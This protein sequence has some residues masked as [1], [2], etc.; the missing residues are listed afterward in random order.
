MLECFFELPIHLILP[1]NIV[2]LH[3]NYYKIYDSAQHRQTQIFFELYENAILL[4]FLF[5]STFFGNENLS[6]AVIALNIATFTIV[7]AIQTYFAAAQFYFLFVHDDYLRQ[8]VTTV[9]DKEYSEA[10][11]NENQIFERETNLIMSSNES[12]NNNLKPRLYEFD[13]KLD[14]FKPK[15]AF[16]AIK[17]NDLNLS[18]IDLESNFHVLNTD[19]KLLNSCRVDSN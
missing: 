6:A 19:H 16:N 15:T 9:D 1:V 14:E 5:T 13:E 2:Y 17:R 8:K 7:L 3:T 11:G 18:S 10:S 12:S 4:G